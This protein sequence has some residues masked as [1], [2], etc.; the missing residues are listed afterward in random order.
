MD[1]SPFYNLTLSLVGN[2]AGSFLLAKFRQNIYLK[3]KFWRFQIAKSEKKNEVKIA[4][5]LY[6]VFSV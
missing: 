2:L 1:I 5:F 4:R 6:L 3:F